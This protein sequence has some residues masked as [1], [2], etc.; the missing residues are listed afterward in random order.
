MKS[1]LYRVIYLMLF[2]PLFSGCESV[3][4]QKFDKRTNSNIKTIALLDV[5]NPDEYHA[6]NIGGVGGGTVA[7]GGVMVG[8]DGALKT[9]K[10]TSA[11]QKQDINLGGELLSGL[12]RSL[13]A[14][15]YKV[16]ILKE[17]RPR[18]NANKVADYS[19]IKTNADAILDVWYVVAGYLSPDYSLDY[20]PWV[21]VSARMVTTQDKTQIYLQ[22]FNYGAELSSHDKRVHIPGNNAYA[23]RSFETLMGDIAEAKEGLR[24]SVPAISEGISSQL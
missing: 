12:K 17:T 21:R 2:L 3:P 15:G 22:T 7:F 18:L 14:A 6:I 24:A 1:S 19:Q 13:T 4:Q 10:F 8:S 23:Y 20:I 16:V 5:P 9:E 11:M